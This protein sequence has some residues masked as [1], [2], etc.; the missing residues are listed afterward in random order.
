MFAHVDMITFRE[1]VKEFIPTVTVTGNNFTNH[2]KC[3]LSLTVTPDSYATLTLTKHKLNYYTIFQL[4]EMR[5]ISSFWWWRLA[6]TSPVNCSV[7]YVAIF[8]SY[9][10][11]VLLKMP[12]CFTSVNGRDNGSL[13]S[14]NPLHFILCFVCCCVLPA[15][16]LRRTESTVTWNQLSLS[17]W[18][19]TACAI[20]PWLPSHVPTTRCTCTWVQ[21]AWKW[22]PRWQTT[23]SLCGPSSAT[24]I[25]LRR[26]AR[27]ETLK[28][29]LY[30]AY[31]FLWWC[32]ALMI[33]PL[34]S[35]TRKHLLNTFTTKQSVCC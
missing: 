22:A 24:P 26:W 17:S 13:K 25:W 6:M 32:R 35:F 15:P 12:L 7:E 4:R 1:K 2:N 9:I 23:V 21:P 5:F 27:Q 10:N 34:C 20:L 14:L 31:R 29:A 11:V 16:S 28:L 33:F 19:S 3:W 18:S 8:Y 30:V